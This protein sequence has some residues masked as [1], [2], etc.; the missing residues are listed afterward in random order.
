MKALVYVS[1]NQVVYRDEPDP[2][3][4]AGEVVVRIDAVG[5]C[6]SDMHGY[7]GH[8]PRRA[9]PLILGHEASGVV[10]AGRAMGRRAVLNPLL[11]CGRCDDCLTGRANLCVERKL[12]GMNRPGAFAELIAMPEQ[13]LIDIPADMDAVAAALT[14]PAATALHA[15]HLV[16]RAS[17]RPLSECKALIL[18]GGSIGLFAALWLQAF[19]CRDVLL[20]E[21]NSLRRASAAQAGVGAVY[22]PAAGPAPAESRFHVVVDAV[23]A[24]ATRDTAIRAVRQGGVIVHIGL[25]HDAGEANFRKLTLS[26][27]TFIGTYTYTAVDLRASAQALHDGKLGGLEWVERRA[28]KDGAAAFDDLDKGRTGAGKVVL[29]PA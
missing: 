19:G 12:I 7:H 24:R 22:D 25:L 6:G 13:N 4:G 1:P 28:L 27:V 11:T 26:E 2:L 3:P 23:G 9:P 29:L 17:V 16:Q 10:V 14:E 15:L 18:G 21:T 5:I 20:G 8:D